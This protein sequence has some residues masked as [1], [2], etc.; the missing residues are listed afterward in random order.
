MAALSNHPRKGV[1]ML[2]IGMFSGITLAG[3]AISPWMPLTLLMLAITGLTQEVT[4]AMGQT[5]V[6]LTVSNEFR[7][8]IMSVYMLLW[9]SSPL[10]MLPAGVFADHYGAPATIMISGALVIAF[11]L[12]S[13]RR[14]G[15]V[16]NF[17]EAPLVL[18]PSA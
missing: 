13:G 7:G 10:V 12:I 1:V 16:W 4:M 8:R 15:I 5:M 14:R 2:T 17:Q 9:A 3:F 6:N 18:S 11:F